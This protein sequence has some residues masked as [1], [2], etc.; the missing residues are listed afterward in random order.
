MNS[1]KRILVADDEKDIRDAVEFLLKSEGYGVE[2]AHDGKN[3][4]ELVKNGNKYDCIILDIIMPFMSG[5]ECAKEIRKISSCPILF[6][7]AKSSDTDKTDA[8]DAGGDDYLSKPFSSVEL[9]LRIRTLIRRGASYAVSLN[10]NCADK[11]VTKNG[12]LIPLTDKEY[13]LLEFFRSNKG[14]VFSNSMIYESVWGEKYLPSSANTVMVHILNLRKKL[15][16]DFTKPKFIQ[17]VW[18]KGYSYAGE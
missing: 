9:L 10:V 16:D 11:T 3:A 6:L 8:Y 15:E 12:K 14:K 4:L 18:G 17:T 7:T 2:K 13:E 5:V 1:G